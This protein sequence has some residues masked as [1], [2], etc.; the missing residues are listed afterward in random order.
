MSCLRTHRRRSRHKVWV[1]PLREPERR[2]VVFLN[3]LLLM[4]GRKPGNLVASVGGTEPGG[5]FIQS[6]ARSFAEMGGGAGWVGGSL[7]PTSRG[8]QGRVAPASCCPLTWV[9]CW[10][11]GSTSCQDWDLHSV[12]TP[13]PGAL[14]QLVIT[15]HGGTPSPRP[16]SATGTGR[17]EPPAKLWYPG[18]PGPESWRPG[19]WLSWAWVPTGRPAWCRGFSLGGTPGP[20]PCWVCVCGLLCRRVTL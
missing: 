2:E 6:F 20:L 4:M 16:P 14:V 19:N 3:R 11:R 5:S 9:A 10:A 7:V 8:A 1:V 17:G 12:L 18:A 15:L 13:G